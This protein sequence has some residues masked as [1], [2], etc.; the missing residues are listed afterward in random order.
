MRS[1]QWGASG[2]CSTGES[3]GRAPSYRVATAPHP[4][5]SPCP[6]PRGERES[7]VGDREE[8]LVDELLDALG[9]VH[10][11]RCRCCRASPPPC[12]APSGAGP[13]SA[14]CARSAR[15]PCRSRA[16]ASRRGCSR[17][18]PRRGSS[19]PRSRE[20]SRSHTEPLPRGRRRQGEL[21]HE[22]AVLLEDLD[23]VVHPV[24]DVDEPVGR[25][26]HAVHRVPELL[27]ARVARRPAV[28][29]PVALVGAGGRVEHDHPVVG[30]AVRHVQLVGRARPPARRR[31]G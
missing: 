1:V 7:S 15:A 5:P 24:A 30:V 8:A 3:M 17:R 22:G 21:A 28:G 9:V 6:L 18:R 13:R 2:A 19:G 11:G 14:R 10:L 16:R 4:G 26:A 12:C 23:P 27:D 20:K 29:A 25:D 31:A